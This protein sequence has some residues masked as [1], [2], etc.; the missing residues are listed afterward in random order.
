MP[1][2]S[3]V[4]VTYGPTPTLWVMLESLART[5]DRTTTEIVVVTQPDETGSMAEEVARRAPHVRLI[6][7]ERNEGFGVANNIGVEAASGDLIALL[8]PD[9]ELTEGWLAPLERALDDPGVLIAAPPLLGPEGVLEEAGQ[10]LFDDGG[11]D[12][13]GGPRWPGSYDEVMFS[14]DVDYSSAACWLMRRADFRRL[15]GFSPD[16][17]PAYFEDVDLA[18]RVWQSSGRCRLV[19]GR[20]VIHHHAPPSTSRTAVALR[21]REV[22]ESKWRAELGGQPSRSLEGS[23]GVAIRDHRCGGSHVIRLDA[24]IDD[25]EAQRLVDE[26]GR[27]AEAHPTDRVTVITTPRAMVEKWRRQWCP[28]GLE[29]IVADR[30]GEVVRDRPGVV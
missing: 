12:P 20:S 4:T 7:L 15:G 19:V 25:R 14:R 26:A 23:D 2:L 11:T 1:H 29:V 30:P 5:T 16:Y 6:A 21:S 24:G 9:L 22:F 27:R 13:I 10:V 8:N 3:C 17:A 28:I 18:M